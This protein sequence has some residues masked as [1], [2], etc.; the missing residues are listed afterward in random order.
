M[1][2]GEENWY[3]PSDQSL[4]YCLIFLPE[5]LRKSLQPGATLWNM[6]IMDRPYGI[7][8]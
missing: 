4:T 3:M 8:S 5:A 6:K 1:E 2:D 7:I